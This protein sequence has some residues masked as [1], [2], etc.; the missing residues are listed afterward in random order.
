VLD[1]DEFEALRPTPEQRTLAQA[2]LNTLNEWVEQG[3]APFGES[4]ETAG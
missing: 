3:H 1:E 2:A 4:L